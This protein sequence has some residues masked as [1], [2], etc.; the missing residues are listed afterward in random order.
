MAITQAFVRAQAKALAQDASVTGST[1]VQLLLTDPG[2]YDAAILQAVRILGKDRPNLRVVD[3]TVTVA[4]FRFV[5]MG[6]GAILPAWVLSPGACVAALA[7]V[8]APGNVNDG[9]HSYAVTFLTAYGETDGG[10]PSNQV[11]VA[12]HLVNGQVELTA[13]PVGPTGTTARKIYRTV[14]GDTGSRLLVGTLA[15]NVATTFTDNVADGALGATV[16]S[17]NTASS[18]DAWLDGLSQ[19]RQVWWPYTGDQGEDPIDDNLWRVNLAPGGKTELELMAYT[20]AMNDVIRLVYSVPYQLHETDE[21]RATVRAGDLEALVVLAASLILELAAVKAAQNTGN[22]SL[23]NDV[24]DRRSQ[25]DIYRSRSKEL[26]DLYGSLIGRGSS[27]D[28][29]GASGIRDLD[30]LPSHQRG[31]LWHSLSTH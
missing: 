23:P 29:S 24:V 7:A 15:G 13:I 12:N 8:A 16:P 26:R 10:Y 2:D 11:T 21:S 27:A 18:P 4:G 3:Y 25:S 17:G 30:V 28:V 31:F 5:L 9:L 19:L 14:A 6:T 20:A 22:T 1:G